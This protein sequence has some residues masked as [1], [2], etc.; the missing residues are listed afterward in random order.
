MI[1]QATIEIPMGSKYK[2]ERHGLFLT[3]DRVLNQK[4]PYNYGYVP[5]V[6]ADDGDELDIFVIT[7]E[8][9]PV[10]TNCSVEI[11]GGFKC[12]DDGVRDDKMIGIL[13]G[14]DVYP[15]LVSI[16]QY[17]STYKSNFEVLGELT[18]EEIKEILK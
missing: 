11:I 2:F 18:Q 1:I 12:L 17:L 15:N 7:N 6:D 13:V 5:E 3:V 10:L 14:E 8:P 16:K 4:I 9:L